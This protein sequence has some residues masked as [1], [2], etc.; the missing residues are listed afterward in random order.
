MGGVQRI[1]NNDVRVGIQLLAPDLSAATWLGDVCL[2]KCL[3][4][5]NHMCQ[6]GQAPLGAGVEYLS[7]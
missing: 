1:S 7:L 5:S 4:L 3:V 2:N 6:F